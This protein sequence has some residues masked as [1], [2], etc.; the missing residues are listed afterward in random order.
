M[1]YGISVLFGRKVRNFHI[2]IACILIALSSS[3]LYWF[4]SQSMAGD[5]VTVS[6]ATGFEGGRKASLLA[7]VS[8][9]SQNQY[10]SYTCLACD[11]SGCIRCTLAPDMVPYTMAGKPL[12]ISGK[13]R[14]TSGISKTLDISR[15][16]YPQ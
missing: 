2:A 13:I 9:V 3:T 6:D 7:S 8:S 11:Y 10:G 5:I 4:L 1:E 15:L 12:L 16:E 14:Y